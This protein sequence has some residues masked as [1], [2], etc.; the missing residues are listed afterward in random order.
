M[1]AMTT[2]NNSSCGLKTGPARVSTT[3]SKRKNDIS[4]DLTLIDN[5]H[6]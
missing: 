4:L 2:T 3:T 6:C 5:Y 1:N